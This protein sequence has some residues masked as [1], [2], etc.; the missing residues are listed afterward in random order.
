MARICWAAAV[1]ALVS[2]QTLGTTAAIS[3]LAIG[4]ANSIMFPTIFTLA[5]EGLGE[6]TANGSALLCMAIV[7]GAVVPLIYGATADAI[8]LGHALVVPACCYIVI[9]LYGLLAANGLSSAKARG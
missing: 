5:L 4:L 8:G 7:G 2:A 3:V 1:L 9:A 6:Q